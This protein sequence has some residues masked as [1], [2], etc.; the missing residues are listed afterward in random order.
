MGQRIIALAH[1]DPHTSVTGAIEAS[2]N[3][4]LGE[5]AGT[6][7]GAGRIGVEIT[8]DLATLADGNSVIVDFSTADAAL[9]HTPGGAWPKTAKPCPS[10]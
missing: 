8:D 10:P 5:D 6:V 9:E 4:L 2:G 7:A 1:A 3:P